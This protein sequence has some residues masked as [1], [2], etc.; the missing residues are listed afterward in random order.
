MSSGV[1]FRLLPARLTL[2]LA[3]AAAHAR[4]PLLDLYFIRFAK[5]ADSEPLCSAYVYFALG[6]LRISFLRQGNSQ[7]YT[8]A[9]GR[10]YLI[11]FFFFFF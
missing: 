11:F 9:E 8:D 3:V 10:G 6:Y 2:L 4:E 5:T 1:L 7:F